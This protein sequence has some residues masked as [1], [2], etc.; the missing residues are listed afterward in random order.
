MPPESALD[1]LRALEERLTLLEL[2]RLNFPLDPV[3]ESVLK[4][5][6][7]K[8]LDNILVLKGGQTKYNTGT[9]FFLGNESAAYKFSIGNAT[10]D[11]LTWDG[12]TLVYTGVVSSLGLFGDGSDGDVTISTNTTLSADKKYRNLTINT[13]V[14]LTTAGYAI[15]VLGTLTITGTGKIDNSG[16]AGGNGGAASSGVAGTAG[17]AGAAAGGGTFT[18]GKAGVAGVAGVY[19]STGQVNGTAGNAGVAANPSLGA[20]GGAGGAGGDANNPGSVGGAAGAAG[21]ATAETVLV[22]A[23][24][25]EVSA[26]L[27]A[28]ETTLTKK[29]TAIASSSGLLLSPGASGGSGGSGGESGGNPNFTAS[30]GS[31]G[32]GA[33]GGV[34]FIAART[35]ANAG[36]IS[37]NGGAGGAAGAPFQDVGAI[38]GGSGGGG[39]GGGGAVVLVYETLSGAG[40][41]TASGGT[42]GAKSDGLNGGSNGVVGANGTAGTVYKL[43]IT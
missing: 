14:T 1:Q 24:A 5:E 34:V 27:S 33:S 26:N 16:G 35:I 11:Y 37:A 43:K 18:A 42:G 28:S 17:A 30:G 36:T 3:S 21:T 38:V 29:L 12:S 7:Q 2:N 25:Y 31:G 13:G 39:G 40:T 6:V 10:T 4:K 15:Y 8:T 32:S 9:G 22:K 41:T 20:S 19:N 23:P